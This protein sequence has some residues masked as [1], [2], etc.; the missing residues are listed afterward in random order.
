MSD[1]IK[2]YCGVFG[3]WDIPE[4][5][6]RT[7]LGL[8]AL[9]HRG[10]EGA[11]IISSD[12]GRF[13]GHRGEGLVDRVFSKAKLETLKGERAI[14]HVRYS[15]AGGNHTKNLQPIWA[16]S[17]DGDLAIAH[18][19]TLTNAN[20]LRREL[21]AN[22]SV[23]QSYLDTEVIIHLVAKA[24]GSPM[25]RLQEALARVK[26]A[27]SLLVLMRDQDKTRM[28]AIKDPHGFRP[29]AL[30]R[31]DGGYV[32]ASET[33]A[34]DLV[35]AQYEREL[36]PGEILEFSK[37]GLTKEELIHKAPQQ[38]PCVFEWIYFSRPDSHVFGESVYEMRKKMGALHA[39]K[40]KAAGLQADLVI[41]V[42]DS[43]VPAALGYSH[44]SGLP[45]E[46]GLIRNHYIGRSF[47]EPHQSIRDFKI[48]I[49]QN[50]LPKDLKGKRLVVI[51]DSIVRGTTSRKINQLL[52][53][54][55]A[56]EIHLRI[57]APPTI[58]PCYYGIDT[59]RKEELIAA[60]KSLAEIKDFLQVDSLEYLEMSEIYHSLQ[61]KQKMC[62]ACFTEKYPV[63]PENLLSATAAGTNSQGSEGD[64]KDSAG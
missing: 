49:K 35:G 9:Q 25:E 40:D 57:A 55:G 12:H 32:V 29:L 51:D 64:K 48:K 61:I 41:G 2:E 8:F 63:T 47:I 56:K 24:K 4:A 46:M 1:S 17:S 5:A 18:N 33:C 42:P 30:G 11:G 54:A 28:F 38:A 34:F 6:H 39:R 19:G 52:K 15:T 58:S 7:Y 50:P 60:N 16:E 37:E 3:C 59:P 44:E 14:G 45:F 36:E 21:E 26:G 31:L 27:F 62:D 10:Q 43:G 22:G 13:R 23:F 20:H 53:E